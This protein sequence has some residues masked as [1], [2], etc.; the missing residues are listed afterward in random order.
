VVEKEWGLDGLEAV[1][2]KDLAAERLAETIQADV[3]LILTNTDRVYLH[4]DTPRQK[5]LD[6]LSLTDLKQ[7]YQEGHFP[8][9]SMGPKMLAAIRFLEFG[10]SKVVISDIAHGWDALQ[11]LCGTQITQN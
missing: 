10:G 6:Q 4:Y 3:L 7:L 11:G 2:D 9:G 1:I 5:P 8:A